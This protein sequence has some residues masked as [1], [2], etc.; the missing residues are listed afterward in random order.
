MSIIYVH[1]NSETV[2]VCP[3]KCGN[4][5][6][7]ATDYFN[8]KS[9]LKQIQHYKKIL[10]IREPFS[11]LKSAYFFLQG[12]KLD[13]DI[14][15][16]TRESFNT[17]VCS[18]KKPKGQFLDG[19]VVP[20]TEYHKLNGVT[21][22]NEWQP[23]PTYSLG[24]LIKSLEPEWEES[25]IANQTEIKWIYK[26]DELLDSISLHMFKKIYASDIEIYN[27]LLNRVASDYR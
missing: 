26:D 1:K 14:Y 13:S 19:H 20:Q 9:T 6:L 7:I 16:L 17:F 4:R 5:T 15:K 11:R 24:K 25:L 23:V 3:P 22:Y 18:I 12:Y 10:I 2:I 27:K 8:Q 21:D